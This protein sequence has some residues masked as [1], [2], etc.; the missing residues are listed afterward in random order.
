MKFTFKSPEAWAGI[1]YGVFAAFGLLV[2]HTLAF[3]ALP[4]GAT[5]GGTFV[6]LLQQGP[7][8]FFMR[9]HLSTTLAAL[10]L[11]AVLL[12]RSPESRRGQLVLLGT[13]LALTVV[14]WLYLAPDVL[15]LPTVGFLC[16]AWACWPAVKLGRGDA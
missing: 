6:A 11:A 16:V 15:Y 14:C 3:V 1:A 10:A 2:W 12:L 9:L 8:A 13:S 5:P 7:G 4:S